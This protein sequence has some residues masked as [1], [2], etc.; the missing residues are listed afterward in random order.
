MKKDLQRL[1]YPSK[2]KFVGTTQKRTFLIREP[3]QEMKFNEG[4]KI[5]ALA[6]DPRRCA[7]WTKYIGVNS[8]N[9]DKDGNKTFT[10]AQ[11]QTFTIDKIYVHIFP[12]STVFTSAETSPIVSMTYNLYQAID[13]QNLLTELENEDEFKDKYL[14]G[15]QK[16]QTFIVRNPKVCVSGDAFANRAR[17][18]VLISAVG[19]DESANTA[20]RKGVY[21][22]VYGEG[23]DA[24]DGDTGVEPLSDNAFNCGYLCF[25]TNTDK[26][27][28]FRVEVAYRV[29][30]RN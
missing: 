9:V 3:I 27:T 10:T 8:W 5:K 18:E 21:D 29:T 12:K 7:N 13:P 25:S 26:I 28:P 4:E 2:I 16:E 23:D 24:E 1:S 19:Y 15:A 20:V 30:V 17:S 14:F 11:Y 22:D 6:L